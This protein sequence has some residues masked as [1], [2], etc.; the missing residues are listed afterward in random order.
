VAGALTV[1]GEAFEEWLDSE[2]C[3]DCFRPSFNYRPRGS[4][5]YALASTNFANPAHPRRFEFGVIASS[6]NHRAR[7]GTGYK[8][9][10][11]KL[12]TEANG[13]RDDTWSERASR[14]IRASRCARS[15]PSR[16]SPAA[17]ST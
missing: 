10:D 11:R 16:S 2:P 1:P 9:V 8:P 13:L 12:T 4:T 5:Q 15:D 6:D 17:P 3:R 7:P 14:R